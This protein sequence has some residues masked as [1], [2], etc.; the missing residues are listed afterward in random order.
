MIMFKF[1][2]AIPIASCLV[3]IVCTALFVLSVGTNSTGSAIV[4]GIAVAIFGL[5]S[6]VGFLIQRRVNAVTDTV[7]K[8]VG[9]N[10]Q[11]VTEAIVERVKKA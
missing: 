2:T 3:A 8:V 5:I 9:D 11:K 6:F 10:A 7:V 1:V 4:S